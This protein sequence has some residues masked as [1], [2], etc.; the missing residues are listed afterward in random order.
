MSSKPKCS[1]IVPTSRFGGIDVLLNSLLLQTCQDFELIIVDCIHKY[2]KDLVAQRLNSEYSNLRVKH[3]EPFNNRFPLNIYCHCMNTGLCYAESDLI[4]ATCDYSWFDTNCIARHVAFYEESDKNHALLMPYYYASLPKF[5]DKFRVFAS[6]WE[7]GIVLE[8]VGAFEREES[9]IADRQILALESGEL[10]CMMWSIFAHDFIERD[11]ND[12]R[13]TQLEEKGRKPYGYID[14]VF[15]YLKNESFP[16][17]SLLENGCFD[18]ALDGS[19]GYQDTEL[20]YRLSSRGLKFWND[21]TPTVTVV[22]PREVLYCRKFERYG[23]VNKQEFESRRATG[24]PTPKN[25][26]DVIEM[27]KKLY[28]D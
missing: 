22:N 9:E 10:D 6:G 25:E 16:I 26:F 21:P 8:D 15:C 28:E 27:R 5:H 23:F 24:F 18:E 2:R 17:K 11:L 12:I 3:V 19:H 14:P 1:I 7:Y 20:G 13:P 4:L